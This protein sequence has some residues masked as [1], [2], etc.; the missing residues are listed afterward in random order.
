MVVGGRERRRPAA[1]TQRIPRPLGG[2]VN[3]KRVTRRL[4]VSPMLLAE[5]GFEIHEAQIGIRPKRRDAAKG[6]VIGVG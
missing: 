3:A 4:K 6:I 1:R 2:P 5:T